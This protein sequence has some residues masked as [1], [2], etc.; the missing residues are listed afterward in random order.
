[1]F[2]LEKIVDLVR[3]ALGEEARATIYPEDMKI[4]LMIEVPVE[5]KLLVNG[6]TFS[7]IEM[8]YSNSGMVMDRVVQMVREISAHPE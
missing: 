2:N 3:D 1:M 8:Q 7:F 6:A 5:G 4:V